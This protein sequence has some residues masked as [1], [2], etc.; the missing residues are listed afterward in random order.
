MLSIARGLYVPGSALAQEIAGAFGWDVLDEDG[1]VRRDVLAARAF[2]TPEE[3]RRLN[4]LVHPVL[5]E[6]LG[7]RLLPANC[8]SVMMPEH[9]LAVVEVSAPAGFEDAFGL[10]DA[11]ITITAPREQRRARARQ[12][13]MTGEDFDRRADVQPAEADLVAL[14]DVVIDNTAA[15]DTLFAALDAFLAEH[16][17][18]QGEGAH[19]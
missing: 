19:A 5:L 11:V 3:T 9:D 13:G 8:C 7:L 15:D 10:A 18:L 17:L 2:A 4:D 12:R 16:G 6:Q 1:G 14:A